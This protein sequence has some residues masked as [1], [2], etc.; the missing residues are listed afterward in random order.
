VPY[1][2]FSI[3]WS[4]VFPFGRGPKNEQALRHYD[5]VIETCRKYNVTPVVTLYHF[6]HP[7]FLQNKYGGWLSEEIV[8]DFLVYAEVIFERYRNKVAH[9]YTINEP[10]I[11]CDF[12]PVS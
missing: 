2:S 9:W 7:L 10:N 12:Y 1:Y 6:D 11:Y 4:R 5:D 3:S 8:G